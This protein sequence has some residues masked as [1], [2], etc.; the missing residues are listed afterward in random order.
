MF[1]K[2]GLENFMV[3]QKN[4]IN[5]RIF[6]LYFLVTFCFMIVLGEGLSLL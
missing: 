4:V 1:G 5:R 2:N 3:P 6:F